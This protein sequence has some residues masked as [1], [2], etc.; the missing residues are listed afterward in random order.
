MRRWPPNVREK[1]WVGGHQALS[2][3][4][5]LDKQS[6]GSKS[7]KCGFFFCSLFSQGNP[8]NQKKNRVRAR[9]PIA[10][11]PR[12]PRPQVHRSPASIVGFRWPPTGSPAVPPQPPQM[13]QRPAPG[14]TP[15][16]AMGQNPNRTPSE[17]P[18][19]TTKIGSK[20]GDAPISKWYHWFGT[21]ARWFGAQPS[22]W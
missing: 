21:M 16:M 7:G 1:G 13:P 4:S 10:G 15:Q 6:K 17:H 14:A 3:P 2:R 12:L 20:M 5:V 19:P 9:A 11:G 8:H 18:N 22:G